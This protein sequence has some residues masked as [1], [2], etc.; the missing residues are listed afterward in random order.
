MT[1]RQMMMNLIKEL[2]HEDTITVAFCKYTE[3]HTLKETKE[4]YAKA[5]QLAALREEWD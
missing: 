3:T 5:K 4:A 2:G 1:K